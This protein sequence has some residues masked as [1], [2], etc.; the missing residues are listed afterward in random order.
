MVSSM[1]TVYWWNQQ[2]PTPLPFPLIFAVGH[3]GFFYVL[4]LLMK[5]TTTHNPPI[6][7]H[8]WSRPQWF[9]LCTPFID[10]L[11]LRCLSFSFFNSVYWRKGKSSVLQNHIFAISNSKTHV[12]CFKNASVTKHIHTDW[13]RHTGTEKERDR[14][15]QMQVDR[16]L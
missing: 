7:P 14:Q 12:A 2:Q 15:R 1:Y 5:S 16:Q 3:D 10:E 11:F 13:D 8:L 9:L 4:C 6:S